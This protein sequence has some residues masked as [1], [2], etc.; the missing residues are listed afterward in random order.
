MSGR[1]PAAA[2][3][4]AHADAA[5]ADLR[6][7]LQQLDREV[8]RLLA[9]LSVEEGRL[10]KDVA[11]TSRVRAQVLRRIEELGGGRAVRVLDKRIQDAVDAVIASMPKDLRPDA[12]P[13]LDRIVR[14]Q[15]AAVADIFDEGGSIVRQAI[16]AG[17]TTLVK[18]DVLARRVS[19]HLGITVSKA[20]AVVETAIIGAGRDVVGEAVRLA[21]EDEEILV[22]RYIGPRDSKTR[23]FCARILGNVYTLDAVE[24]LDNGQ[25]LP[26][27]QFGGGYR[28]RHSW[29]PIEAEE[30]KDRGLKIRR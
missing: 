28:C 17:T 10:I 27:L 21:N 22:M 9:K 24:R 2:A 30:A 11:T 23:P 7:L 5:L 15:Y 18:T 25:G 14:R 8:A 4:N 16:N 13:E 29:V 1:R 6:K 19:D 20:S 26:V 12:T 3:A